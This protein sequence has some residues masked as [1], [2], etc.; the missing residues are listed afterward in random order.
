MRVSSLLG[1]PLG[2]QGSACVDVMTTLHGSTPSLGR[3]VE[4]YILPKEMSWLQLGSVT[5]SIVSFWS[6]FVPN[7]D[8]PSWTRVRGRQQTQQILPHDSA[9]YDHAVPPP[10]SLSQWVPQPT[11]YVLHS[12]IDVI[13]PPVVALIPALE[14]VHA[15]MDR[16]EQ[17]MR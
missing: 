11:S 2:K 3:H 1:N 12:Q 16:L 15:H 17:R 5:L 7:L 13:P 4:G 14:D 10:P 6:V 9:Q 8:S